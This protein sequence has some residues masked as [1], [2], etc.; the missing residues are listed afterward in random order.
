MS[1]LERSLT[2]VLQEHQHES[3]LHMIGG[4]RRLVDRLVQ[5]FEET[6]ESEKEP[7]TETQRQN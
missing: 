5:F 4:Q 7:R 1:E 2:R 6:R 3:G